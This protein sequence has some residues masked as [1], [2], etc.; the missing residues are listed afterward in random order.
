MLDSS[1]IA[2]PLL[3][4]IVL[5]GCVAGEERVPDSADLR[6]PWVA[7]AVPSDP[8]LAAGREVFASCASCHL[9]DAGGRPDGAIPR[10]AG[11]RASFLEARLHALREG[12][13][14][15]PVMTPFARALTDVEIRQVSAYLSSLPRPTPVGIAPGTPREEMELGAQI[16]AERCRVCHAVDGAGQLAQ[17]APRI[18]GQHEAYLVRRLN[19]MVGV[20]RRSA[21][22]AMSTIAEAL[23]AEERRVVSE[24]LARLRC[25]G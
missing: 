6:D 9:A 17:N 18:C 19:E 13:L 2:L 4:V 12:S 8:T 11:Q 14:Y 7:L 3:A 5:S 25:G 15:L 10:L 20:D 22:T 1:T 21:E 23:S 24:H 16:Y